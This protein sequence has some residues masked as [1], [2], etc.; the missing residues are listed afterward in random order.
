[1]S[2]KINQEAE[3]F[4]TNQIANDQARATHN[5]QVAQGL[6]ADREA[7]VNAATMKVKGDLDAKSKLRLNLRN[8][9]DNKIAEIRKL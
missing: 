9:T 5:L 1:M 7:A 3:G 4:K 6:T 2:D 8:N